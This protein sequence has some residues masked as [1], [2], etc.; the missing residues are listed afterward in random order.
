MGKAEDDAKREEEAATA[1]AAL[2]ERIGKA[3]DARLNKAISGHLTRMTP[4]LAETIGAQVLA[5]I[6]SAQGG[7]DDDADVAGGAGA[8]KGKVVDKDTPLAQQLA[9]MQKRLEAETK[10]REDSERKQVES[11]SRRARAEEDD[12]VKSALMSAGV[13]DEARIRAALHTHRGEGRIKRDEAGTI[14]FIK[15]TDSGDEEVPLSKGIAEWAKT[16]EG[17]VF[18]PPSGAAGSGGNSP[19]NNTNG[20]KS[21]KLSTQDF[22][23]NI[24]AAVTNAEQK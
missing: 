4:K 22:Q 9:A 3:I 5:G 7:D 20:G 10:K 19:K 17:K 23:N 18:L 14:L 1:E 2:E 12:A 6:K 21:T 15:R 24:L 11:E 16:D 13:K 8:G